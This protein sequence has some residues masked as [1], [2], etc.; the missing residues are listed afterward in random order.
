[1]ALWDDL[2]LNVLV[3]VEDDVELLWDTGTQV[4]CVHDKANTG[5]SLIHFLGPQRYYFDFFM[6]CFSKLSGGIHKQDQEFNPWTD[7]NPNPLATLLHKAMDTPNRIQ[8]LISNYS[9]GIHCASL[10]FMT[11]ILQLNLSYRTGCS[12]FPEK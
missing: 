11:L 3:E 8:Y 10:F 7:A 5:H 1:M 9:P 12:P 6:K 2:A 4:S